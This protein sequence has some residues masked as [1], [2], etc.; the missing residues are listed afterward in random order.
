M[1]VAVSRS[2]PDRTAESQFPKRRRFKIYFLERRLNEAAERRTLARATIWQGN[3]DV[4]D[5]R[6][7]CDVPDQTLGSKIAAFGSTIPIETPISNCPAKFGAA[8]FKRL[9]PK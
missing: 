2:L 3:C 7:N 6:S 9:Y 1:A 8:S 4:P 5:R